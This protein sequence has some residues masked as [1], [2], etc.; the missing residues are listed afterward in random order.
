[1][2]AD[3][4]SYAGANSLRAL[5]KLRHA[6]TPAN[7]KREKLSMIRPILAGVA[8]TIGVTVALAQADPITERKNLMKSNGAA[9]RTGTQ[10]SRGEIPF[11]LTKAKEVFV[12]YEQ[13][14]K[15]FYTLFPENTKTGDTAALPKIWED[16]AGFRAASEKL[17]SDAQKASAS[18]KDLDTFK[19]AFGEVTKNCG[20]CH[21]TY[22]QNRS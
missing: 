5:F 1:M 21:Q 18:V 15:R 2:Q 4:C 3:V 10:M 19:A 17:A 13:V 16:M 7:S 22:R 9:T 11:D 20:A 12:N 8:L 14:G 6:G